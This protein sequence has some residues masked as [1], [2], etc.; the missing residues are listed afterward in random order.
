MIDNYQRNS[1]SHSLYTI[2][3]GK[4]ISYFVEKPNDEN[5]LYFGENNEL[6]M[7]TDPKKLDP[8]I[9]F[10]KDSDGGFNSVF[11]SSN[12][13]KGDIVVDC[14]YTK[15]FLEMGTEGTP[16]YIQNIVSWLGAPEKHQQRDNCKD[17]TDY[18]PNAIGLQINWDDRWTGFKER[19]K[20]IEK[21]KTL[22]AVDC[23]GSIDDISQLY[24][25][26]LIELKNKY[27]NMSRGDKFYIWEDRYQCLS[28]S[29]MNKFISNKKGNGGTS[30]SLIAEI[31]RIEKNGNFEHLIIVTDGQVSTNDIDTSDNKVKNYGL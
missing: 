23:S 26:K 6:K 16:R 17:G 19:T 13:N 2:Y 7:I 4:T 5:L 21:M 15:F 11:Y 22:F 28:H 25:K 10:S 14:S 24:F 31:G 30:S 3:E 9:P 27:Y 18:R 20:P 8:F 29:E 1:I 12:D